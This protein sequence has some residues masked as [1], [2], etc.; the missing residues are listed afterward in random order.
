MEF[1]KISM[2]ENCEVKLMDTE[3]CEK[4]KREL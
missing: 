2:V 4:K 3:R 1:L